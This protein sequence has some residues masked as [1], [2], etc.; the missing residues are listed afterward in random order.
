MKVLITT[1][2]FLPAVNG[3]VTSVVNLQ[4]QLLMRGVDVKIMTLSD[5]ETYHREGN[6][7]FLPSMDA[8]RIYP[9]ARVRVRPSYK[10]LQEL[11]HWHPDVVHSQCEFSTFFPAHKI[12]RICGC[13]QV[14]T[15]H[16]L[17]EDFVHYVVPGRMFGKRGAQLLTS[18]ICRKV[19]HVIVPSEKIKRLLQRYH[20]STPVSV[21]PT[22]IEVN[23]FSTRLPAGERDSLRMHYGISKDDTVLLYTG[24]LAAEKNLNELLSLF[25]RKAVAQNKLVLVGDGP[26]R[27][28]LESLVRAMKLDDRV[29]FTGMISPRDMAAYY[30]MGDIFV[31]A[32]RS[33]T[34][35][36]TYFEAMASG[37]PLLCR[38]DACLEHVLIPGKT[39]FA[40]N[41]EQ[42]FENLLQILTNSEALR[43]YMGR[44]AKEIVQSRYSA[45]AFAEAVLDVY[46]KILGIHPV[47]KGKKVYGTESESIS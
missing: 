19:Q 6:I 40:Y 21:I 20:V 23:R 38:E 35:G 29:I 13:P 36:L 16:T 12:A 33:E 1:D 3:V 45:E 30:N 31:S 34:Q 42:E 25:S 43:E 28:K 32:S 11:I 15:Y 5:D 9:G 46:R 26:Y 39:G 47:W 8:S 10:L 27:P 37:L 2:W 44:Q 4:K 41:D 17:Y 24:R 22:G 18:S 7:I 14:H